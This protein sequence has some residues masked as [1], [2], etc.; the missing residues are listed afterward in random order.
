MESSCLHLLYLIQ[1]KP[2]V[3]INY[4][5]VQSRPVELMQVVTAHHVYI[6]RSVVN[7]KTI[8]LYS[9]TEFSSILF[10]SCTNTC[11][12]LNRL[13]VAGERSVVP[14]RDEDIRC[15]LGLV[16]CSIR[17]ACGKVFDARRVRQGVR[18]AS[19]GGRCS[20]RAVCGKV[21]DARRER[22]GV[23]CAPRAVRCSLRAA[24]S[25]VSACGKV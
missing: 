5:F 20:M 24:C 22:Q 16:N 8:I 18:C 21:F 17:A 6:Y 14:R 1:L 2:R 10:C 9:H 7:L 15:A 12:K 11:N 13:S 25:K 19:R 4:K 23:R 3:V